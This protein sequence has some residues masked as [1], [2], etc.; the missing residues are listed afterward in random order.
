MAVAEH[1]VETDLSS[2]IPASTLESFPRRR[3]Q[4]LSNVTENILMF[5][6]VVLLG[7]VL[8]SLHASI[9]WTGYHVDRLEKEILRTQKEI[10]QVQSRVSQLTAAVALERLAVQHRR[11][12]VERHEIDDLTLPPHR[13]RRAVAP[14]V[15]GR[16]TPSRT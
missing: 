9:L 6:T 3:H 13:W 4:P 7:L 14:A 16:T 10:S 15:R 11:K 8:A 1:I 12:R 2:P 5:S